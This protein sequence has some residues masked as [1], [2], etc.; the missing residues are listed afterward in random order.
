M[1]GIFTLEVATPEK[2]VLKADCTEAQIPAAGGAI[3]ILP[4]HA[5]LLSELASGVVSYRTGSETHRVV[6]H[7]GW[8]EVQPDYVRVLT[9]AA[10]RP[11]EIDAKR[12][13]EALKRAKTRVEK[14]AGN[15]DVGRALNALKRAQA[16][17]EASK[18]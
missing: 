3:G 9:N 6:I 12:A 13:E 14:L 17:V 10:E 8:V 7:G 1:A 15:V 16:R 2:L 5:P 18:G 4:S 11:N